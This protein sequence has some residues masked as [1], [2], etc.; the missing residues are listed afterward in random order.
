MTKY[1]YLV[2][3]VRA[4]DE[5]ATGQDEV[6]FALLQLDDVFLQRLLEKA[7]VVASANMLAAIQGHTMYAAGFYNADPLLVAYPIMKAAREYFC[8]RISDELYAAESEEEVV[9]SLDNDEVDA[10]DTVWGQYHELRIDADGFYLEWEIHTKVHEF[11]LR[12]YPGKDYEWV[13]EPLRWARKR[14]KEARE[15][16][17]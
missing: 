16:K 10:L 8:D 11:T 12:W 1:D 14:I 5:W 9:V 17:S 6:R 4:K 7:R 15:N 2:L 13:M 3:D